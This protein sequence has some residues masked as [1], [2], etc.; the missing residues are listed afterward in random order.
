MKYYVIEGRIYLLS[1]KKEKKLNTLFPKKMIP[2]LKGN[3]RKM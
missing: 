3:S 1:Q 2:P